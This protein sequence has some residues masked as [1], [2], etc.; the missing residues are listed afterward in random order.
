VEVE[1]TS[2]GVDTAEDLERV[3]SILERRNVI[4]RE[5]T[6]DDIPEIAKVHVESWRRSFQG[7]VPREF[8]DSMSAEKREEA[9]RERFSDAAYK[10]L[11][12]ED[13]EQGIVGFADFGKPRLEGVDFETQ[14]YAFYFLKEFQR[15]GLGSELFKRCLKEICDRGFTN[16]C[17]DSLAVSPYRSFYEKMGGKVVGNDGHKLAGVHFATVIYGWQNLGEI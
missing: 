15:R 4:F 3:R 2:I 16:V 7:I 13:P 12:A 8:L 10:M 5:A 6:V 14:I 17:L 9:F 11:V 1:E